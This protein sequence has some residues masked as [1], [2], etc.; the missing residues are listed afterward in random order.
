MPS[1][2]TVASIKAENLSVGYRL[3]GHEQQVITGVNASLLPGKLICLLGPN[4]SGKSTL[5]RT[6]AGLQKPLSGKIQ[7]YQ[8]QLTAIPPRQRAQQL[9]TVFPHSTPPGQMRVIDFVALGRHPFSGLFGQLKQNDHDKIHWAL[10]SVGATQLAQRTVIE[11]SDGE[12]QKAAIARALAQEAQT[13]LLD[14]PTAYLDLPHRIECMQLMRK[15]CRRES[16]AML[17]STHDLDLALRFADQIW[18]VSPDAKLIQGYPEELALNGQL[19]RCFAH[20]NLHWNSQAGTFTPKESSHTNIHIQGH[21]PTRIWTQRAL[22]RLGFST[23][24]N[25]T[26]SKISIHIS[27]TETGTNWQVQQS[28]HTDT[29]TDL[30]SL[31]QHLE[32][33]LKS[34]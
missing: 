13:M 2:D 4:G 16:I 15:L 18:L 1:S 9:S 7:L 6:L 19:E 27:N 31:L 25:Q 20:H 5:I 30:S 33:T 26:N 12:R 24:E 8:K 32:S 3:K 22:E 21:G 28:E 23:K 14:E 34:K 29:F 17:L 11:L 10:E